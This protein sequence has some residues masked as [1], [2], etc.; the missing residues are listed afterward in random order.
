MGPRSRRQT[1]TDSPGP[2]YQ[3]AP[4]ATTS[5]ICARALGT[6]AGTATTRPDERL[7]SFLTL[8]WP[9]GTWQRSRPAPGPG[10]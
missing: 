1:H 7:R 2:T 9:R 3:A 10:P 4:R 8:R 6:S 5:T